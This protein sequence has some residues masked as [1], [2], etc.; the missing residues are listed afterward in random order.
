MKKMKMKNI[1]TLAELRAAKKE[2]KLK[3]TQS[4]AEVKE[5]FLYSTASNLIK[6]VENDIFL[7]K[8]PIGSGVNSAL[9]FLSNQ[10]QNKF[11]MGRSAKNIMSL[12][13]V[14]LAPIIAKKIQDY[15]DKK[16]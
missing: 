1:K 6:K 16:R 8:T 5:G 14:A 9:S 2:L 4:D 12:A 15:I 3:I 11:R 10:A 13:V 7:Q